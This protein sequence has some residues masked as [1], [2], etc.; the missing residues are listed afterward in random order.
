MAWT[1]EGA[2]VFGFFAWHYVAWWLDY[3]YCWVALFVMKIGVEMFYAFVRVEVT[4][5][6][7]N[8]IGT[9]ASLLF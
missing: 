6:G 9:F 4:I 1:A 2:H 3:P 8:N 5:V 7:R